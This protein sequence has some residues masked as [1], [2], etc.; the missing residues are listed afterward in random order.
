MKLMPVLDDE[1]KNESLYSTIAINNRRY[2]GNKYKLNKFIKKVINKECGCFDTFADLFAGTV[3][4]SAMF[5][6]KHLI[7]NDI[8]YSNY[9]CHQTWFGYESYSQEIIINFIKKYNEILVTADNYMSK[10]YSNTY[11][12]KKNCKKIGFIRE[13]I[14]KNFKSNN[15]N[16]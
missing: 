15:L 1:Q 7:V 8:L 14:E 2:L 6:E 11:F 9:V 12:S 3:A 13:D 16:N 10:N 5:Q 4:V